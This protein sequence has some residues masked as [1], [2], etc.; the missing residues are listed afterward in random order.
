MNWLLAGELAALVV[1]ALLVAPILYLIGRRRWLGR[2]GALFDCSLRLRTTTPDAGWALGVARYRG[3]SLEWFGAFSPS[4]R[5]RKAF[6]RGL[7]RAG[8]QRSPSHIESVLLF[9]DQR[10]ITLE[11]SEAGTWELA[12]SPDSLTGLLSW[13]EAS[14]PGQ[15]Y[16]APYP[17]MG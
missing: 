3:D 14:L 4:L 12:M 16:G 7:T 5:P 13:L 2:R 1:L 17:P 15:G 8:A 6:H 10:I 11:S 9:D